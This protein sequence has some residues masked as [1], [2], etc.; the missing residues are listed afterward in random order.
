[1]F[2]DLEIRICSLQ[3]RSNRLRKYG[4]NEVTLIL[5]L[6]IKFIDS[7]DTLLKLLRAS[8]DVYECLKPSILKQALLASSPERLGEKRLKLWLL[9]LEISEE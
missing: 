1:M 6:T 7:D 3:K 5:G 8:R 2:T 4:L 9:L